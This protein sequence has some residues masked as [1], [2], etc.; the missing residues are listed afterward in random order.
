MTET[1]RPPASVRLVRIGEEHAGQRIDNFL[2]TQLKGVPKSHIY[3]I[4][5]TGQVRLNGGR[6]DAARR[7][8]NGDLVRIPPLQVAA[9]PDEPPSGAVDAFAGRL[10][11][12]I[13]LDDS[14]LLVINKPSGIAVHGGSGLILGIIEGVRKLRPEARF[15]ELVHRLDRET[16]GCLVIAKKRSALRSLH[17]QFR[18]NAVKKVYTALVTG[19]WNQRMR[20]VDAALDKNVLQ[21]GER[22][23]KASASGK[24]ATTTF[25]RLRAFQTATLVSAE[26]HTGRTHQIRVHAQF[27]GHPIAGDDRY[28]LSERNRAFRQQGLRRLFLHA[29]RLTF[30][31]PGSGRPV[32]VE[33][34]LDAELQAFLDRCP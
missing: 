7:I 9:T 3:R 33:A 21:G 22:M 27:M 18:E 13:L 11:P 30:L 14:E 17:E 31:H 2:L 28:G 24:P 26:P 20:M 34:P 4:L 10:A 6:I 1:L 8:A 5:R 29:S 25:R 19:A 32:T 12:R 23:V 16:S 15:L